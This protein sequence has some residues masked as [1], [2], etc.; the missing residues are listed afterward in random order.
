MAL[1][2]NPTLN[3]HVFTPLGLYCNRFILVGLVGSKS[4]ALDYVFD[5]F[6]CLLIYCSFPNHL[7]YLIDMNNFTSASSVVVVAAAV[8]RSILG[9]IMPLVAQ[10]M[11]KKLTYGWS[12]TMIGYI[13]LLLGIPFPIFYMYGE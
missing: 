4:I 8:F 1:Y 3:C 9:F 2:P 5:M 11:Y 6:I 13:A 10:P 12:N 7:N